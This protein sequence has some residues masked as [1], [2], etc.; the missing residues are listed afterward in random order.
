MPRHLDL[1]L[2][3]ANVSRPQILVG[4][5][6]LPRA[7][8]PLSSFSSGHA[9]T[10]VAMEGKIDDDGIFLFD[11]SVRGRVQKRTNSHYCVSAVWL[12]TLGTV[13]PL[14]GHAAEN[15]FL[16]SG[17][18]PPKGAQKRCC[19]GSVIR[20]IVSFELFSSAAYVMV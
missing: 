10:A 17:Q 19:S 13:H 2:S 20:S 16:V 3:G 12:S 8:C 9:A 15:V 7:G 5:C 6:A 4:T 14:T 1:E 11:S 18:S